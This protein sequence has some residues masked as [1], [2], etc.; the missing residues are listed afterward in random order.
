MFAAF[1][2]GDTVEESAYSV[3]LVEGLIPE[4]PINYS[5][6]GLLEK[7]ICFLLCLL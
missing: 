4:M 1:S 5:L 6:T 3:I 2:L 7:L